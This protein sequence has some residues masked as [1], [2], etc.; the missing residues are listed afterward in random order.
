MCPVLS[1]C[2]ARRMMEGKQSPV[3]TILTMV[4]FSCLENRDSRVS[5]YLPCVLNLLSHPLSHIASS[6]PSD[7][8]LHLLRRLFDPVRV[9]QLI[10]AC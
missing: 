3:V 10:S 9:W 6:I 5:P 2:R 7:P 1:E 4:Y 8:F